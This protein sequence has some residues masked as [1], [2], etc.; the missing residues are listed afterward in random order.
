LNVTQPK[1]ASPPP[2]NLE[3]SAAAKPADGPDPQT[4]SAIERAAREMASRK[5]RR[6]APEPGD[7]PAA[8]DAPSVPAEQAAQPTPSAQFNEPAAPLPAGDALL[9]DEKKPLEEIAPAAQLQPI[10]SSDLVA[11]PRPA[12][13]APTLRRVPPPA[14]RPM[15]DDHFRVT[16]T[17]WQSAGLAIAIIALVIG[18]F[19]MAASGWVSAYNW[20]CRTGLASTSCAS[21]PIP[22]P[23]ALPEIP[24]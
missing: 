16:F 7:M 5:P 17:P 24:T 18:A 8:A 4:L 20:S 14:F 9:P 11:L 13:I 12:P 1:P 10:G 3:P 6:V 22:K 19:G 23:L 21:S 2:S 15:F